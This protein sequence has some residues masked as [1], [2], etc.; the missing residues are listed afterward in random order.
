MLRTISRN[1]AWNWLGF[2]VQAATTFFLTPYVIEQLGKG[3]YGLWALAMGLTGYY[4]LVDLGLRGGATQFL[5]RYLAQRDFEKLNQSFNSALIAL[6]AVSIAAAIVSV[7]LGVCVPRF[8]TLPQGIS[9]YDAFLCI[10]IVGLGF[11]SQ[12]MLFPC[13]ALFAA[14]Q[15]YDLSNTIGI[16]TRVVA[17]AG[18]YVALEQGGGIVSL[19]IVNAMTNFGDYAARCVVGL[20]LVPELRI[21]PRLFCWER[22]REF[23]SYGIWNSLITVSH[24]LRNYT[25][26]LIVSVFLGPVA[27]AHYFLATRVTR[28]VTD[29][30][31][32][33]S[34]VFFPA[35]TSLHAQNDRNGLINLWL[36][37]SR[38]VVM[39]VT[40]FTI[41]GWQWADDFYRLWID[42]EVLRE[43]AEL[44]NVVHVFRALL[45]VNWFAF[46]GGMG[47]QI[48][49]GSKLVKPTS[50][51]GLAEAIGNVVL[52]C[53]L[54]GHYGM[55][56]IVWGTL[57]PVVVIRTFITP[58]YVAKRLDSTVLNYWLH[59]SLRP[60][61][62]GGLFFAACSY[63]DFHL[64]ADTWLQ[65]IG[66]G[67]IAAALAVLC[68]GVCG[69]TNDERSYVLARVI[70]RRQST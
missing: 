62:V 46:A 16:I 69:L 55:W 53:L 31:T 32:S 58:W 15:R 39:A 13:S 14:T 68:V 35:A 9:S 33:M 25:D 30:A 48:L 36:R 37:G 4:G 26:L 21:A 17:A 54:V 64:T 20:R 61:I 18:M 38:S 52:S 10:L 60:L 29:L 63:V 2:G 5:T 40:V 23:L 47:H 44:P 51:L 11:A 6:T 42:E 57:I 8:V 24:A 65:L 19:A 49:L 22:M 12:F 28:Y 56:G 66:Q 67:I 1:V 7:I 3:P 27:N 34:Q 43:G 45:L 70:P 59:A 41:I 50:L